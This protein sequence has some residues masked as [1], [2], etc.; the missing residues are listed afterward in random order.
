VALRFDGHVAVVTGAGG[1]PSLGRSYAL[2]LASL[3]ARVVVNDLGTGPDGRGI[4]RADATAVAREIRDAGGEAISDENSVAKPESAR[5]VVQAALDAWGRVDILVNNAG[6]RRH[7]AF[8]EISDGDIELI[9]GSHL[10]GN[11][12]MC[13]AV[14]DH[15]RAAGYGRIVNI[16]SPALL[17]GLYTTIY[18]AAKS[19][20]VGLTRGLAISGAD[21]GINVNAVAPA[22]QT[23]AAAYLSEPTTGV[24]FLKG[25]TPD[26]VAPLVAFLAHESCEVS[27]KVFVAIGG[28][29]RELFFSQTR[30]VADSEPTV[31]GAS[32]RFSELLDRTDSV[33]VPDP[34]ISAGPNRANMKPRAYEP[35]S[36]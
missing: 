10:L 25:R 26:Q 9:V 5:A 17:G 3:G 16:A 24:P 8:E 11:I 18:G 32:E 1:N 28:E 6:A 35:A 14:W 20:V 30:G 31:D 12:W 21:F 13:R 4:Q 7:A 34:I 36:G 22:A 19:G 33:D 23:A 15:M 27:G 29:W 2:L